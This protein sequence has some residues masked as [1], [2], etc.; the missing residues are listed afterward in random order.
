M[1]L[2]IIN[3]AFQQAGVDTAT[4]LKHI[5]RIG[6]DTVDVFT[7]AIGIS[8]KEISLVANTTSKLDLPIVSLP[9]VAVGLVDFNDPVRAF[10]VERC[11]RF[12]DLAKIWGAKNILLVVGEYIWQREVIPAGEQ[13]KW[14]I[15]TCRILGDYADKKKIDIALELEPFRLSLL[16]NVKEM[17]R[18][19]DE[20][21]HP[22]VRANID[23]S[24]LVLSDTGPAELK[25]LK[26]KAIHVHLSD[27]DGKVHGDLPPGRGVVKFAP[28]LQA[29]KELNMDDG[30]VSIE[31]EYAPDPSRIVEWV[32]E[33]YRE[34]AK[35]MD[36]VGLR[37]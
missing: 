9:V 26:G 22:R 34:T 4:G 23:I 14:G 25:K 3:S 37:T 15:E 30:V 24:H 1:K 5:S 11:K 27:C 6:F 31:L 10:H 28:Y 12:I 18:F 32:E 19:V 35:L 16:N 29:I 20:C 36:M 7:E 8:K 2:G 13:W 17:I 33:A 21:N